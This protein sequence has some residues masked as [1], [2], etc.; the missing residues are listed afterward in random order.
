MNRLHLYTGDGKGK[1]T[2]AFGCAFRCLGHGRRVLA[3]QFV[4]DGSSGELAA[5]RRFPEA[6]VFLPEPMRGFT[7]QMADAELAAVRAEQTR[8][9]RALPAVIAEF[10]PELIV[11]DELATAI[12]L[13]LLDEAAARGLVDASLAA[14]ETLVTG[15]GA[16]DW[17]R[18]RADYISRIEC[19]R[20]P[21]GTEGL[22]A[23]EGIEW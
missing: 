2:A 9:A 7:F 11:L 23:R 4:K 15:Q 5:L 6:R 20:H 10:R 1:T 21:Y 17:L 22:P 13:R 3:A 14:G 8:Y 18:E 19:E 12:S 16:P